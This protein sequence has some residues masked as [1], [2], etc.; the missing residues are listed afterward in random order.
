MSIT[1]KVLQDTFFKLSTA[2]SGSLSDQEKVMV[3]R[4]VL[5]KV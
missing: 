5:V 3:V 4:F 1:L 2:Q